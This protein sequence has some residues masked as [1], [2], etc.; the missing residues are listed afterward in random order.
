[1]LLQILASGFEAILGELMPDETEVKAFVSRALG[2]VPSG[3][4]EES[5]AVQ[6]EGCPAGHEPL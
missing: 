4:G 5:L 6:M 1:M 2:Q 3:S